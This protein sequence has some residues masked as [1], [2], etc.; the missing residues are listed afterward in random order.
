MLHI[1]GFGGV[2]K[3][4]VGLI[5][6]L[7]N[8]ARSDRQLGA[9]ELALA[10]DLRTRLLRRRNDASLRTPL[11]PGPTGYNLPRFASTVRRHDRG[12]HPHQ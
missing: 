1:G 5:R 12:R 10:H 6:P 7:Q 11:R 3:R 8:H 9:T 2:H 4:N